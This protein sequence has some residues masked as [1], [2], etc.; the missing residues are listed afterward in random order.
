MK[1]YIDLTLRCASDEEAEICTAFLS[2]YPFDSFDVT[3][4]ERGV[5]LHAFIL[6][7]EWGGC[8]E[9]AL[10]AVA[11]YGEVEEERVMEDENWN[12]AWERDGFERVD[13][14]GRMVIRAPHHEAPAEGIIDIIVAPRMAFGSGHHY[15]SR[16]MCRAIMRLTPSEG[17]ILDVGCGTG[18][19]SLAAL[20]SGARSAVAV[21]IDEWSVQSAEDAARLNGVEERM[22]VL[23]G[24]IESVA[25]R[26]FDMVLANINRNI[27]LADM[28]KYAAALRPGGVLLLSGFL[29]DDVESIAAEAAKCGIAVVAQQSEQ[30][31]I[32]LECCKA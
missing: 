8:R 19:L 9:S 4:A 13:I 2:D 32:C 21:D 29:S 3:A 1:E 20:G 16:M 28:D 6:R 11:A 22:E 30:E 10:A 7:D 26:E 25:G 18:I 23:H 5:V 15:T 12:E 27:I 24:T 14:D 17:D 31:W